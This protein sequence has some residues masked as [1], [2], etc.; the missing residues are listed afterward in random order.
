MQGANPCPPYLVIKERIMKKKW[1]KKEWLEN[2]CINGLDAYSLAV[3]FEALCIKQYGDKEEGSYVNGL[4]GAQYEIA[5]KLAEKIPDIKKESNTLDIK[6]V[7][8]SR[9]LIKQGKT[10][11]WDEYKE[12]TSHNNH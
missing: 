8:E 12:E 9:E 1:T 10:I 4:S 2:L 11:S 3:S 7:A 6:I 5:K